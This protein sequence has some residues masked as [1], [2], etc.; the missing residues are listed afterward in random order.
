MTVGVLIACWWLPLICQSLFLKRNNQGQ[1]ASEHGH[2]PLNND[3]R[4]VKDGES[5]PM[6]SVEGMLED[7]REER[8]AKEQASELDTDMSNLLGEK[9]AHNKITHQGKHNPSLTLPG[10]WQGR[11]SGEFNDGKFH[12]ER[13]EYEHESVP[14]E[15]QSG[16]N[17]GDAS[18]ELTH[19]IP[20]PP[21]NALQPLVTTHWLTLTAPVVPS[22]T[23]DLQLAS[24]PP[25]LAIIPHLPPFPLV[26]PLPPLHRI[27]EEEGETL[28]NANEVAV[29]HT[30]ATMQSVNRTE[31]HPSNALS[32]RCL[33]RARLL[34]PPRDRP[35]TPYPFLDEGVLAQARQIQMAMVAAQNVGREMPRI[36]EDPMDIEGEDVPGNLEKCGQYTKLTQDAEEDQPQ[37]E[38]P[39]D[40]MP[41]PSLLFH[42]APVPTSTDTPASTSPSSTDPRSDPTLEWAPDP[43]EDL[44]R[45][46]VAGMSDV[47]LAKTEL[48]STTGLENLG[49]S[50]G[51]P[52]ATLP[53]PLFEPVSEL[54]EELRD[55]L[56][57]LLPDTPALPPFNHALQMVQLL[58]PRAQLAEL[59]SRTVAGVLPNVERLA[60]EAQVQTGA[61][62]IHGW[63]IFYDA[64]RAAQALL[65]ERAEEQV[66]IAYNATRVY[67]YWADRI[68]E[69]LD[70]AIQEQR[71]T[72]QLTHRRLDGEPSTPLDPSTAFSDDWNVTVDRAFERE[73]ARAEMG[74]AA[75]HLAEEL[76]DPT[77]NHS[78]EGF[79]DENPTWDTEDESVNGEYEEDGGGLGT[80]APRSLTR[81]T[82]TRSPSPTHTIDPLQVFYTSR[83]TTPS[84]SFDDHVAGGDTDNEFDS[85]TS[86]DL[87]IRDLIDE[88]GELF[89]QGR[90][91]EARELW[92]W[93]V[94]HEGSVA[95]DSSPPPLD[96]GGIFWGWSS[97]TEATGVVD[98]ELELSEP[99]DS[100][101]LERLSQTSPEPAWGYEATPWEHPDAS[102][103]LDSFV[104][105]RFFE[106][107][108]TLATTH[109]PEFVTQ[110]AA[111]SSYPQFGTSLRVPIDPLTY[112][113]RPYV[114]PVFVPPLPA[115]EYPTSVKGKERA[116]EYPAFPESKELVDDNRPWY[117]TDAGYT[118]NNPSWTHFPNQ[119]PTL[120]DAPSLPLADYAKVGAFQVAPLDPK[121]MIL[122][123]G[124][125]ATFWLS[126]APPAPPPSPSSNSSTDPLS[127]AFGQRQSFMEYISEMRTH[128]FPH[129]GGSSVG[130]RIYDE[131]RRV[132]RD[133][134]MQHALAFSPLRTALH[135]AYD[136][137]GLGQLVDWKRLGGPNGQRVEYHWD[138]NHA[139]IVVDAEQN[140]L[141]EV[142]F[143]DL[144]DWQMAHILTYITNRSILAKPSSHS[145]V[146]SS[147]T[148]ADKVPTCCTPSTNGSFIA[149]TQPADAVSLRTPSFVTMRWGCNG[150]SRE[151]EEFEEFLRVRYMCEEVIGR[152]L[153]DGYLDIDL[154][155]GDQGYWSRDLPG[156]ICYDSP[157]SS[158]GAEANDDT[159]G[160]LYS[161]VCESNV[162]DVSSLDWLY[163]TGGFEDDSD[164]DLA[165]EGCHDVDE[166]FLPSFLQRLSLAS[167]SLPNS[168]SASAPVGSRPTA[169]FDNVLRRQEAGP[170][171]APVPQYPPPAF[172]DIDTAAAD[173]ALYAL[174][175]RAFDSL[176]EDDDEA[177]ADNEASDR[178]AT[179]N[180]AL[181]R[182]PT[183][184][185]WLL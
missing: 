104:H 136:H 9:Q 109:A 32:V 11:D 16:Y 121:K 69:E 103:S 149:A 21:H 112:D 31:T 39:R 120:G 95:S 111:V 74:L 41:L 26:V 139:P 82:P 113:N 137:E 61:G 180:A 172:L 101:F 133:L 94:S 155:A 5:S 24:T 79:N 77:M 44:A 123:S 30:L 2:V 60:R 146:E 55:N 45:I 151:A 131:L 126:L 71:L 73:I 168:R 141:Q 8:P 148:S 6:R 34:P 170:V 48:T 185:Q 4:I 36:E 163:V 119:Q 176:S 134:D 57:H 85:I 20:D 115:V 164:G 37:E 150:Y 35:P 91:E 183:L 87:V 78:Y 50:L 88:S 81:V 53:E 40:T 108:D 153:E 89:A 162:S 169:V 96:D 29:V 130:G 22:F 43:V 33:Q 19:R 184:A 66:G 165:G 156:L 106:E 132:V 70:D 90:L 181:T 173:A 107:Q 116:A 13:P 17:K 159:N 62:R 15:I 160:S 18:N 47:N 125:P 154:K 161:D 110:Q 92:Y 68:N 97:S 179:E 99:G 124:A 3:P 7:Q 167:S 86:H 98:E 152:F 54:G 1:D 67:R 27:D 144:T 171:V 147:L 25:P 128:V 175:D 64:L 51:N 129:E 140:E 28:Y 102:L 84:F 56:A 38:L 145:S 158:D 10:A 42:P 65:A 117:R 80:T 135:H 100:S 14:F 52:T 127:S 23:M 157:V 177:L 114:A 182:W 178:E 76:D 105:S 83:P 58:V 93:A 166:S 12:R 59:Y 143:L 142:F 72:H 138:R 122:D 75:M 118:V 174:D 49:I 63:V 46:V